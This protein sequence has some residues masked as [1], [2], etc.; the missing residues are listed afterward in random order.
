MTAKLST[1]V[2]CF[3]VT[4]VM[5]FLFLPANVMASAASAI[6]ESVDTGKEEVTG[7]VNTS[8]VTIINTAEEL[9]KVRED[10]SGTYILASDIDLSESE[11]SE[12]WIPIGTKDEPFLGTFMGGTFTIKGMKIS[13][14]TEI[15]G[16]GYYYAGLFGYNQ[17]TICDLR[18]EGEI[19]ASTVGKKAV[20]GS[21]VGCNDGKV[22]NCSD[23]VSYDD[24]E[25]DYNSLNYGS[26]YHDVSV[27]DYY[28]HG[29]YY[30]LSINLDFTNSYTAVITG[31]F[32][33]QHRDDTYYTN[34]N[35]TITEGEYPAIYIVLT[36]LQC[37]SF[38]LYSE[39]QK[40]IYIITTGGNGN[41]LSAKPGKPV[42]DFPKANVTILGDTPLSIYGSNGIDGGNGANA[43]G[44]KTT[45]LCKQAADGKWVDCAPDGLDGKN[46]FDGAEGVVA[47]NVGKTFAVELSTS[48]NI[49][50]FGGHGGYGGNGGNGSNGK[51]GV[52]GIFSDGGYINN[53]DGNEAD[54]GYSGGWGGNGGTGG[55]GGTGASGVVAQNVV[56][57]SPLVVY[58][59][60]G[61]NGGTGGNGGNGGN[62]VNGKNEENPNSQGG[63]GGYGGNGGAGG[64]G[65][66]S[67][68]SN[69]PISA[70]TIQGNI[71][72]YSG[73]VTNVGAP[74]SS[75]SGGTGGKGGTDFTG[76]YID[77]WILFVPVYATD[78]NNAKGDDGKKGVSP[79]N[80][81]KGDNGTAHSISATVIPGDPEVKSPTYGY[82]VG[83][84]SVS[85]TLSTSYDV[86]KP[87]QAL[88]YVKYDNAYYLPS[89]E[90]EHAILVYTSSTKTCDIHADTEYIYPY[91]FNGSKIENV[92][93]PA[94]VRGIGKF[95]FTNC[96]SLGR[97]AATS[98]LEDIGESAFYG[99]SA[100]REVM[101]PETMLRIRARAFEKCTSITEFA[102]P[103]GIE[104]VSSA[105]LSG[106]IRLQHV[107]IPT[108][109]TRIEERAF[110]NCRNLEHVASNR[111]TIDG[112]IFNYN[113]IGSKAF[114][115]CS[116]LDSIA[117]PEGLTHIGD[118]A[119][120]NAVSLKSINVPSTV[121]EIFMDAFK[122]AYKLR[123]INVAEGNEH[124]SSSGNTLIRK[125]DNAIILGCM[126]S[127]VRAS[128]ASSIEPYAFFGIKFDRPLEISENVTLKVDS[129]SNCTGEVILLQEDSNLID[130]YSIT[131]GKNTV[132]YA[133]GSVSEKFKDD[134]GKLK[135]GISNIYNILFDG[136][137]D[138]KDSEIFEVPANHMGDNI[139]YI[140]YDTEKSGDTAKYAWI[141]LYGNGETRSYTDEELRI[142]TNNDGTKTIRNEHTDFIF[143]NNRH[144]SGNGN[145]NY[146]VN[147]IKIANGITSIGDNLFIGLI[148]VSTV[149]FGKDV[150]SVGKNN[151]YSNTD[152]DVSIYFEGDCPQIDPNALIAVKDGHSV[153]FIY[154]ED[155]HGWTHNGN[156]YICFVPGEGLSTNV[157]AGADPEEI[158]R[159][160]TSENMNFTDFNGFDKYGIKYEIIVDENGKDTEKAKVVGYEPRVYSSIE[161]PL[162]VLINGKKCEV[163]TISANAF[164]DA[165]F[166]SIAFYSYD[167]DRKNG[168][169]TI[170]SDAFV[171]CTALI[172]IVGKN[173]FTSVNDSA[174]NTRVVVD[175]GYEGWTAGAKFGGATVYMSSTLY[176]NTDN[177][178]IY[179]TVNL[180]NKTAIVGKASSNEDEA[181]NTS[182][183]TAKNV[184]IND[185]VTY[186]GEVYKVVGF[187]R[188]AFYGNNIVETITFGEFIGEGQTE[189]TPAIW[190]CTF[191]DTDNLKAI[192]VENNKLYKSEENAI[193]LGSPLTLEEGKEVIFTRIVKY[194]ENKVD[195]SY[196]LPANITVVE[197]YAF[198]GNGYLK[199]VNLNG[200]TVI[201][202]HAFWNC[203]NLTTLAGE[204]QIHD[205]GSSAFENTAITEFKFTESLSTIGER[206]FY[207]TDIENVGINYNVVSIGENAFG[208]CTNV[209]GFEFYNYSKSKET[210]ESI[211]GKYLVKDGVLY[212]RR[213][214]GDGLILL[215]FPASSEKPFSFDMSEGETEAEYVYEVSPEAFWGAKY[216]EEI[217]LSEKTTIV[218][219]QAFANCKRLEYVYLGESYY[220]TSLGTAEGLY[221][222]NLFIDSGALEYIEVS[223]ENKNFMNDSNGVLFSKDKSILYCYP[224]AIQRVDYN[225]PAS[226]TK[227]YDAAF[228]GNT[229]VKRIVVGTT[230]Q[231]YIGSRAFGNCTSLTEVFYVSS[232]LPVTSEKI[233]DNTPSTLTTY[234]KS[235]YSENSSWAE[236]VKT[237]KKEAQRWCER[238]IDSYS[239]VNT[240]PNDTIATNDYLINFRGT[241]GKPISDAYVIITVYA[242]D[243][244]TLE[245]GSKENILV[246][247]KFYLH[248]D[249][250]G[251][252]SFST[253]VGDNQIVSDIHV[254]AY[255]ESYFPYDYDLHLDGDMLITY[256]TITKEPD[257]FGVDC[258]T[259]V[260]STTDGVSSSFVDINSQTAEIN[261]AQFRE[262]SEVI[263]SLDDNNLN[264]AHPVQTQWSTVTITVHGFWDDAYGNP[265][266]MLV[267]AGRQLNAEMTVDGKVC[268]FIVPVNE[269][270]TDVPVE[271][272]LTVT[273]NGSDGS[274][275]GDVL[276]CRKIL[277]I[278][279]IDFVI[280]E[281][282]VDLEFDESISFGNEGDPK[283]EL[284]QT[285]F[286]SDGFDI[287]LGDNVKFNTRINGSQ[288]ILTLSGEKGYPS[289]DFKKGY[290]EYY[291]PNGKGTYF[292]QH[293]DGYLT[294]NVRFVKSE[295]D[296][297][298]YF[299]L[300]VY[301]GLPGVRY[302][303]ALSDKGAVFGAF[304]LTDF[305]L[306]LQGREKVYARAMAIIADVK[307]WITSKYLGDILDGKTG[308]VELNNVGM[309]D[310]EPSDPK[311]KGT[312]KALWKE[313]PVVDTESNVQNSH[314]LSVGFEG[315]LVF[316]YDKNGIRLASGSIKGTLSFTFKHNSQFTI[317]VIPVTLEVEVTLHGEI[318]L[319][320]KF[321]EG[322]SLDELSVTLMADIEASVGVGCS[323]ASVG[324]YGGIGT[325]FI[326]DILPEFGVR[327]WEVHGEFG[328]Y[329]KLLW[330]KKQFPI[331]S[332]KYYI[333][334]DENT[335]NGGGSWSHSSKNRAMMYLVDEYEYAPECEENATIL[336]I[337]DEYYKIHFATVVNDN[338]DIYNCTKL[339]YSKWDAENGVWGESKIIDD[340]GYSDA[341]YDIYD[342]GYDVYLV[343][344]QQTKK[345]TAEN[346]EDTY[347]SAE[348]L[349][350]YCVD[351]SR[352]F[353]RQH[354]SAIDTESTNYKYA[355]A[356]SEYD[357]LSVVAWAENSDN[358]LFGV[359]PENRFDEATNT[360]YVYGTTA[361]SV[362]VSMEN[363]TGWVTTCL[364]DGLSSI[365]DLEIYG[366]TVYYIVDKDGD[367][368]DSSDCTLYT[369]KITDPS[370]EAEMFNTTG[371]ITSIENNDGELMYYYVGEYEEGLYYIALDANDLPEQTTM[372]QSGYVTVDDANGNI[373]AILY[374]DTET[375]DDGVNTSRIMGM[376]KGDNG[377]GD[378]VCVYDA[379]VASVELGAIND[380]KLLD[381]YISSFDAVLDGENIVL[382][383]QL[384]NNE[385]T[386]L[387]NIKTY[388]EYPDGLTVTVPTTYDLN[389]INVDY[390][391]D[392]NYSEQKVCFY[393]ENHGAK[394]IAATIG[395]V[396]ASITSGKTEVI[397]V[398]MPNRV[399]IT[400][401]N[402]EFS[403]GFNSH[404][405]TTDTINTEF[406]DLVPLGKQ[407]VIGSS[408]TLLVAIRNYG[409][410]SAEVYDVST[411]DPE[412]ENTITE[413]SYG[414]LYI[415]PG[416]VANGV[417]EHGACD[418]ETIKSRAV[419]V[420]ELTSPIGAN[421]IVY[422]EIMLDEEILDGCDGIISLYVEYENEPEQTITNNLSAYYLS[423]VSQTTDGTIVEDPIFT[424][425]VDISSETIYTSES[426]T[427]GL[428]VYISSK[429]TD[430]DISIS[431]KGESS[432]ESVTLNKDQHYEISGENSY[433]KTVKF[434]EDYLNTLAVGKYII[435]VSVNE[436]YEEE[437]VINVVEDVTIED[438]EETYTVVW[439]VEGKIERDVFNV[440]DAVSYRHDEPT[441][442][443][444]IFIGWD[445]P[446]AD[447]LPDDILAPPS[448]GEN[449]IVYTAVFEEVKEEI[450]EYKITF[451]VWSERNDGIT[452][453]EIIIVNIV[454]RGEMPDAPES[455]NDITI[456]GWTDEAG[457]STEVYAATKDTKYYAVYPKLD[458][459]F[460][461]EGEQIIGEILVANVMAVN[462]KGYLTYQW[463]RNGEA[464]EGAT[465]NSY[466]IKLEDIKQEI[467]C[468]I[469]GV[470]PYTGQL[471]S[472]SII[473]PEHSHK[474]T[475]INKKDPTCTEDGNIAHWYC[476]QCDRY[477]TNIE[478]TEYK[479]FEELIVPKREH[480]FNTVEHPATCS[481]DGYTLEECKHCGLAN[482]K[483]YIEKLGHDAGEWIVKVDATCVHAGLE[484]KLCTRCDKLLETRTVEKLD[485][486]PSEWILDSNAT[487][488]SAGAKHIECTVCNTIL[489]SKTIE[490]LEHTIIEWVEVEAACTNAGIKHL[491]CE[492]CEKLIETKPIEKL[493][494]TPSEWILDSNATCTSAGAKH[495]E[496]TVCN[497]ILESKTIEKLEHTIIEWV[498]VEAA[499]T[500][501]GIKHLMC[502]N[503]EKLIETK[504]IE[505][506]EHTPSEW[507]I[508][509]TATCTIN[510]EEH[511][512]CTV[513]KTV[514]EEKV[515]DAL[516]HKM[517]DWKVII[518]AKC[519]EQG[520]AS[521]K[522]ENCDYIENQILEAIGHSFTNYVS[523]NDATYTEDG[524]KTAKCDHE[525]CNATDTVRD[526]GSAFGMGKKFIDTVNALSTDGSME[527][528]YAE[529]YNALVLYN[530]LSEEEKSKEGVEEAY[531]ALKMQIK[532]YN[533]KADTANTEL[534]NAS[535]LSF[536]AIISTGF[537]F[538][539]SLWFL[540][541]KKFMI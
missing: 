277:N 372:L 449:S 539:A 410:I 488:T 373:A 207:N 338:Y 275:D 322:V 464:I 325:V 383:M 516:G 375:H 211:T 468:V 76:D 385:G 473:I 466:E 186:N 276:T 142:D 298:Y 421:R 63:D 31:N 408:N 422:Y 533:E 212:E 7:K 89:L 390:H 23:G 424:P 306:G 155:S 34:L 72:S 484:Q 496:C 503:C 401:F 313:T 512:E 136:I 36:S 104:V 386:S 86:S 52:D 278:N 439:I 132:V 213:A 299:R 209:S 21:L 126:N 217:K 175:S 486:T 343:Y 498:E 178:G 506:L 123:T 169:S 406:V 367:L 260:Q 127:N 329:V 188:Y 480:D 264:N 220:G 509:F 346:I 83:G 71:T 218:G 173:T 116:S 392:V 48:A 96:T 425:S 531:N 91:A 332:G 525:G 98:T 469:T 214:S 205:L 400:E 502:E 528:T 232:K 74:G 150:I 177:T 108:T 37:E 20:V 273:L 293:T 348:G 112:D 196:A 445:G 438:P 436:D 53:G 118:K 101:L 331:W 119:F 380:R 476:S 114:F 266:F 193:L 411:V 514:L 453:N 45:D 117:L 541:K 250:D 219:S 320:L 167:N 522:C 471:T 344:T 412:T 88:S 147:G 538:L 353:E 532:A 302:S 50:I 148:N 404:T 182:K 32:T 19:T 328:A 318:L 382:T 79:T 2:I 158:P 432:D 511:I 387:K 430:D 364:A 202:S 28:D 165:S 65:G 239:V 192:I 379:Y 8:S 360:S 162:K 57:T 437:F 477:Y 268:K 339:C 524:T 314:K 493:D 14:L 289:T 519:T 501:A 27:Y 49:T 143:A 431:I 90:N 120:E 536:S 420:Q 527:S 414:R 507:I 247:H 231:L 240:L 154:D 198:A 513:C 308:I 442:D 321:D 297:Y 378:P 356:V 446:D 345:L 540:L 185:Y 238:K 479:P 200:V 295:L 487:C 292:Y 467:Y 307:S 171:D 316:E 228:Y 324:I 349:A 18:L 391:Y 176:G 377:W 168:I 181:V 15:S 455:F 363:S 115:G 35:F 416:V 435:T 133:Y 521:K 309:T 67:G 494:H 500:N 230:G 93:I 22:V 95:A 523:N 419:Y 482:L 257:I 481:T 125:E 206:A 40:D 327:E 310:I 495:I 280:T 415:I 233:Y 491:M 146:N 413:K 62:G 29:F 137:P 94:N 354:S 350:M 195:P 68:S 122:G 12:N 296:H 359:S 448:D 426:R 170:E 263:S 456:A 361:N 365:V 291:Q 312:Y 16:D 248:T 110:E 17:G 530:S 38:Y 100:L 451:V 283:V 336:K 84:H 47:V 187:D 131:N 315:Q 80:L 135:G 222:Y 156:E 128:G 60:D 241:D 351:L 381:I 352:G 4:F 190:D 253:L 443:G 180:E 510:G 235:E 249:K 485:H 465:S 109:V 285:L 478:A 326:L 103:E 144:I 242:Q 174:F 256:L 201:G 290:Y 384:C 440:S 70:I 369:K 237:D 141:Y 255:K 183:A 450:I 335:G 160:T 97:F 157:P 26:N 77:Y 6:A 340:N 129:I 246:P 288:I 341:A 518:P 460:T 251:R 517:S 505:K 447:A 30:D 304:N 492:N 102:F 311:D 139:N 82:I 402:V 537:T 458:G 56:A 244:I 370:A 463:Y 483:N 475:Y 427:T 13:E 121:T 535:E 368:T 303:D 161:I 225:V 11:Y 64:K 389:K 55:T 454:Q 371:S 191:R 42:F 395:G 66:N 265:E 470:I 41:I 261:K 337:R 236:Y 210:T 357:G 270:A 46:G 334:K 444:Y 33:E 152:N 145:A 243:T 417:D 274:K 75:G 166:D 342:D 92:V 85:S 87:T 399:T 271:A 223:S 59:G 134:E 151:F 452:K 54:D 286:G 374:L 403:N 10:L 407:I 459:T 490:K 429:P 111:T 179:Y 245:D 504:P 81:G 330:F 184:K 526:Y 172:H 99:D 497:T 376:F 204:Y 461:I 229:N 305:E 163:T 508:D 3:I 317:W 164:K 39:T 252:V 44:N 25:L 78:N 208:R 433:A 457:R 262:E 388:E 272:H 398:A 284:F 69:A 215:Q 124:Y 224:A 216:V 194:P 51:N 259:L 396:T 347:A 221:S 489:E 441:K 394:D 58:S 515:I 287:S 366:D 258:E 73:S 319:R 423:I 140:V 197:N 409:N 418:I 281:D 227:I 254:Y 153:T 9:N 358:N 434:K 130:E 534:A 520:I 269:L 267:Q 301:K 203:T 462:G 362:W 279:V 43:T 355:M 393:V 149:M 397:E 5:V 405:E 106:A 107:V 333:I 428:E 199:S 529:L 474:M 1:R 234:F 159:V 24:F 61:G 499:C 282:D 472:N 138:A 226:V 113:Y 105:V 300:Y 189:A 323:V 294:Y